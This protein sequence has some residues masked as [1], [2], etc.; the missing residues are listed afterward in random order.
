M[1]GQNKSLLVRSRLKDAV[2]RLRTNLPALHDADEL[3]EEA[4]DLI[5]DLE[6]RNGEL[7]VRLSY[8]R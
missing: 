1:V 2:L 4:H 8:V 5:E 7:E 3:L 6:Y